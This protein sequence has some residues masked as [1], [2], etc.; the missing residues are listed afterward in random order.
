MIIFNAQK[1]I[2][3]RVHKND[4]WPCH[5]K[6]RLPQGPGGRGTSRDEVTDLNLRPGAGG[7]ERRH[8]A[9]PQVPAPVPLSRVQGGGGPLAEHARGRKVP[10]AVPHGRGRLGLGLGV[11]YFDRLGNALL[12]NHC[13]SWACAQPSQRWHA[14]HTPLA[15]TSP[16][17]SFR[18]GEKVFLNGSFAKSIA[19]MFNHGWWRLAVGDWWRLAVGNWRL[20]AVRGGWRRLVVGGWWLVVVGSGWRLAVGRWWRLAVGGGWRLVAVGGWWLVVPWGGP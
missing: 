13:A 3:V 8:R 16:G 19:H 9:L 11:F 17:G 1:K 10:R 18:E 20:V 6:P 5:L 15:Q 14:Q 2:G 4:E 12:V 7:L